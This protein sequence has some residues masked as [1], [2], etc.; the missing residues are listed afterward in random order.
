[1]SP[2]EYRPFHNPDI[3]WIHTS[4]PYQTDSV[5]TSSP[6]PPS[7]APSSIASEVSPSPAPVP[8]KPRRSVLSFLRNLPLPS[9]NTQ[10]S[11]VQPSSPTVEVAMS[12]LV[13]SSTPQSL[14]KP[15][16]EDPDSES[17]L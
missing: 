13:P 2:F 8:T 12:P 15:L 17:T 6:S 9:I 4:S 1:M 7:R 5:D 16:L 10:A 11:F 14:S 3:F